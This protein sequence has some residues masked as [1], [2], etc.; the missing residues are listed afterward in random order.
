MTDTHTYAERVLID[1][2]RRLEPTVARAEVAR[3]L[4]AL[5]SL[6]YVL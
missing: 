5:R 1:E 2:V 6:R 3:V 4:G